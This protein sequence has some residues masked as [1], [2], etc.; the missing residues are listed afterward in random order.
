MV[1]NKS[2][3]DSQLEVE[4]TPSIFFPWQGLNQLNVTSEIVNFYAIFQ[5]L[6][7]WGVEGGGS[8]T[9]WLHCKTLPLD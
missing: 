7:A 9:T 5:T 2:M 3:L 6:S 1:Y 4:V 8:P